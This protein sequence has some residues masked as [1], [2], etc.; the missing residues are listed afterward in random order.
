MP[1]STQAQKLLW[2]LVVS[3]HLIKTIYVGF[4]LICHQS[5]GEGRAIVI[6][7]INSA[8]LSR[9]CNATMY[10][11][12]HVLIYEHI[13]TV[14]VYASECTCMCTCVIYMSIYVLSYAGVT[15]LYVHY[16]YNI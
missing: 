11:Y 3:Q 10:L 13:H 5:Q 1:R 7:S 6:F 16:V 9:V 12:M 14:H 15:I 4:P 2:W 8:V